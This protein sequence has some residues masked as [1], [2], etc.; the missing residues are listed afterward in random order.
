MSANVLSADFNRREFLERYWQKEP[1]LI[2]QLV[3]QLT[4]PLSPEELAGCA[5]E[6][7][8]ESRVITEFEPEN[9]ALKSGPF[10]ESDFTSLP[11]TN[12]TLLVQAMDQWFEEVA[13]LRKQ[14][15][16]IPS[17]RVD[18]VMI[19]F[20][21]KDGG[22]GPHFDNYDVFLLQ[23]QGQRRWRIGQR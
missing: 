5:C 21:C 7:L 15:D 2:R 10:E 8:V 16:F 3:P 22:V 20:A 1:V 23:G 13:D 18:D 14:F 9:F 17:W 11:A 4:D 12:W 6:E 19:S